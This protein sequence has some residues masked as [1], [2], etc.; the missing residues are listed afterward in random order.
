MAVNLEASWLNV[1]RG[2]FD[3]PYMKALRE[4]LVE[5]KNRGH[6]VFP[7]NADIFRAFEMTPFEQVKVVLL[8]Q[9]PYHGP[10]QA[11]GLSFSVQQGVAVPPSL[12][13]MYK[14]LSKDIPGFTI[15]KH[16]NLSHWAE[17][18]V[19][20]LNASLTVRAHTAGS[21][22]KK[23]WEQFTDTVIHTLSEKRSGLIFLLWGRFAQ[24]K[25]ALIDTQKHFILRA[26]HPSPLSAHNGFFGSG[27]FSKAN[28]I[29]ER[30]G[31][32]PI[33]WQIV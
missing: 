17:Q 33:D 8:G 15:P 27:H 21:H 19:L 1:L 29:L 24:A 20:L 16:G 25:A 23:G 12:Q 13:N 10:G 5:E 18:G 2:E 30:E 22:Q 4:Y 14:E 3:K 7:P 32:T 31:K 11:H 9:D 28:E 26:A 6:Q